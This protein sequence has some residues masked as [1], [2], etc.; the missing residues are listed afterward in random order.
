MENSTRTTLGVMND[1]ILHMIIA[2]TLE[3]TLKAWPSNDHFV[4]AVRLSSVFRRLRAIMTS[5]PIF[6]NRLFID[7]KVRG[8]AFEAILTRSQQ[9][10]LYVFVLD[11]VCLHLIRSTLV[12]ANRQFEWRKSAL[13]FLKHRS[14]ICELEMH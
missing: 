1:D 4:C 9:A 6:W 7:L 11:P 10:Q 12:D 3:D 13:A 8:E 2:C 14:R 5:R